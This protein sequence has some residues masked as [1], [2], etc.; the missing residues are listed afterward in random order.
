MSANNGFI[1]KWQ[2]TAQNYLVVR[3]E[4]ATLN[5]KYYL[6]W[7][8]N[9]ATLSCSINHRELP[10]IAVVSYTQLH[11]H[12]SCRLHGAAQCSFID[13][14]A[15]YRELPW[16]T[17]PPGEFASV[18]LPLFLDIQN[19]DKPVWSGDLDSEVITQP[20][21]CLIIRLLKSVKSFYIGLGSIDS[22][23]RLT[24]CTIVR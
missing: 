8:Y 9:C 5:C 1:N 13:Y 12:R 2:S 6:V 15:S 19:P 16:A 22:A 4:T 11:L 7:G 14:K 17:L 23:T 24:F 21:E 20:R 3:N 10:S 18:Q